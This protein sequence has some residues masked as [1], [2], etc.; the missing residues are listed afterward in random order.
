MSASVITCWYRLTGE[1]IGFNHISD[2]Y[3]DDA[4]FPEP[5]SDF[6]RQAWARQRWG[7]R[8]AVLHNGVVIEVPTDERM[9]WS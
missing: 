9:K 3:D 2:G 4:V 8:L 5:N 7:A 6:Q 1:E